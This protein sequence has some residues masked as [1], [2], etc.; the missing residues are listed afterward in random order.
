MPV[1][2]YDNVRADGSLGR[3]PELTDVPA[4]LEV[5]EDVFGRDAMP[6]GEKWQA[7]QMLT[8]IMDRMYRTVSMPPNAP[9]PAVAEL[10]GAFE[11]LAVD[12]GYIEDDNRVVKA[13]PCFIFGIGGER[14]VAELGDA[15]PSY[16]N[17]LRKYVETA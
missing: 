9:A 8:R 11:K 6:S 10:R 17:F 15:G 13:K 2:Q 14:I 12:Q 16:V 5:Y 4:F 1:L 7:L 3:S